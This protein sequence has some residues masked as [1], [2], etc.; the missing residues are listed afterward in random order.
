MIVI[1]GEVLHK[2]QEISAKG[3]AV[4]NVMPMFICRQK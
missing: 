4:P 2:M 1:L 3:L